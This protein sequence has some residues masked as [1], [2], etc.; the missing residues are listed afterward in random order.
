MG[1]ASDRLG[2]KVVHT[3]YCALGI[4]AYL[5]IAITARQIGNAPSIVWL[6]VFY[7]SAMVAFSIYGG[8]FVTIG[9]Y[10]STVFGPGRTTVIYCRI[11]TAWSASAVLGPLILTS[12]RETSRQNAIVEMAGGIPTATFEE[13]F[14]TTQDQIETLIAENSVTIPKL[15]EICPS[16]T[17]DPT[18][19]I[20]TSTMYFIIICLVL[21]LFANLSIRSHLTWNGEEGSHEQ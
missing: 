9:P 2:C 19:L 20:Y 17:I 7:T 5:A 8:G 14:G 18:P 3:L 11:L 12:L 21:A 1:Q 4:L 6:I 10:I 15:L 13:R 16:N